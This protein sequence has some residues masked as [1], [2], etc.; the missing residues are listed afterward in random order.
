MIY[1]VVAFVGIL[2][3]FLSPTERRVCF[4]LPAVGVLSVLIAAGL[5]AT[6]GSGTG[7]ILEFLALDASTAVDP[8]GLIPLLGTGYSCIV[9]GVV[10]TVRHAMR[11]SVKGGQPGDI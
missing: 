9:A 5:S 8:I 1:V 10:V 6:V 7:S 2:A 11:N 3:G 4:G